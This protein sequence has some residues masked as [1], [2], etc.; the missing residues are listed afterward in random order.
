[1]TLYER[2]SVLSY[3]WYVKTVTDLE[4]ELFFNP[5]LEWRNDSERKE[6]NKYYINFMVDRKNI[7]YIDLIK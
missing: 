5:K 6:K 1:M 3:N 7:Y 4:Q 2:H